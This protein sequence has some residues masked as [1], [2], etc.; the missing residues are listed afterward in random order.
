[1]AVLLVLRQ[2]RYF[3]CWEIETVADE[4]E[5]ERQRSALERMI[6]QSRFDAADPIQHL[7][8]G[9]GD[10]LLAVLECKESVD[11]DGHGLVVVDDHPRA[12]AEGVGTG[13]FGAVQPGDDQLVSGIVVGRGRGDSAAGN[14]AVLD[15]PRDIAETGG[16]LP[17]EENRCEESGIGGRMAE[18][19]VDL[20]RGSRR[21]LEFREEGPGSLERRGHHGADGEGEAKAAEGTS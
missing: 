2:R 20:G 16:G 6:R 21:S 10:E 15:D 19:T 12:V 1:M 5:Q 18:Q 8:G 14:I 3:L 9:P 13:R 17:Q 11:D 7:L 4:V